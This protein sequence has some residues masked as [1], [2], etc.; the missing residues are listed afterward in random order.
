MVSCDP[1][2]TSGC[3]DPLSYLYD[4]NADTD[5]GSCAYYYGGRDMGQLDLGS[6]IDNNNEYDVYFDG[7]FIGRLQHYWPNGLSCGDPDA[8]GRILPS[9]S[10]TIRAVGNGATEI[11]EGTVFLDPQDCKVVLL[12]NLPLVDGSGGGGGGNST[13]DLIFWIN[14]DYGCGPVSV[15]LSGVGSATINGYYSTTPDCGASGGANFR[16]ISPGTYSFTASC[17]GLNWSGTTTVSAN[18]CSTQLLL[19]NGG[20]GGGGGGGTGDVKFWINQDFNCG[21]ITVNV[22]GAGSSVITGYFPTAP[23][24]DNTAAGGNFNNLSP[25]TYSYTASC[26]GLNWQGSFTVTSNQCLQFQLI[27]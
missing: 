20:S 2:E 18:T 6:Q 10:H 12:E 27:L 8:V 22:S 24:C 3:T 1:E 23:S 19:P 11:R 4:E 26:N 14:D 17:Q 7:E 5:D 21:N 15:N 25:G 13:G 16:N 9:G